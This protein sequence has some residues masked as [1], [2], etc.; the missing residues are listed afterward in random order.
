VPSN[1]LV[2][3]ILLYLTYPMV[4][5]SGVG[6]GSAVPLPSA[7][8]VLSQIAVCVAVDDT[9]FYWCASPPPPPPPPP[10]PHAPHVPH[11]PRGT[12]SFGLNSRPT[13]NP[14]FPGCDVTTLNLTA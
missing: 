5:A 13:A 3:P 1:L 14:F 4:V 12:S 11:A 9:V 8:T 10:P 2:R 7:A 6:I